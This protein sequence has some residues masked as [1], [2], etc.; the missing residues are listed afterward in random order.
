MKLIA[1]I[2]ENILW[3][4]PMLI[5]MFGTGIRLIAATR[6]AL[7]LHLGIVI[8]EIKKLLQKQDNKNNNNSSEITPFQAVATALAGTLGTGNIIGVA[9][10]ISIGG[11]GSIF[12]MWIA[13][14]FGIVIKYSE[15]ALAVEY[16]QIVNGCVAGGPMYYMKNGLKAEKMAVWFCAAA[17]ISSFGI[18]SSVQSNSIAKSAQEAFGMDIQF[19]AIVVSVL[20]ALVLLGGIKRIAGLAQVLVPVMAGMYIAAALIVLAANFFRIPQAFAL[21]VHDAFKGSAAVGGFAGATA[22]QACRLGLSRGVFTNEAGLGSAPIAHAAGNARHP[23]QQGLL[24][25]FEVFADTIVTCTLTALVIIVTGEWREGAQGSSVAAA[26][27]SVIPFG[28][29][30]YIVMLGLILFAFATIPAWYYYGE[31]CVEFLFGSRHI[32]YYKAA[33]VA[34]VYAGAVINLDKVWVFADFAN[35]MM[36]IPNL[37]ALLMLAPKV[38]RITKGFFDIS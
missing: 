27:D 8:K 11:P 22:M 10:A 24:G 4:I 16:R 38:G 31:K 2:N 30:G 12:W 26:F 7:F 23:A 29:G 5:L 33:Y 36:A 19:T 21:I 37:T 14:L 1:F 17:I 28:I 20:A 35:A 25:A 18:G 32:P 13:A 6:G 9:L 15:A 3:G 34:F